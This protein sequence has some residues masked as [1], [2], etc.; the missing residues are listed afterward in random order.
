[1]KQKLGNIAWEHTYVKESYRGFHYCT[2]YCS[3]CK[4]KQVMTVEEI[5]EFNKNCL[6]KLKVSRFW[7]GVAHFFYLLLRIGRLK[8][9]FSLKEDKNTID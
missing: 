9:S 4:A 8:I 6:N 7:S 3:G 1:M 5:A 2:G